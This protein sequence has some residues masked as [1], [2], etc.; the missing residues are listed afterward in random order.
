MLIISL[1]IAIIL[2]CFW[3][4]C[5]SHNSPID[6]NVWSLT[7]RIASIELYYVGR[8]PIFEL[9][10]QQDFPKDC[11]RKNNCIAAV[12]FNIFISFFFQ[13]SCL[14]TYSHKCKQKNH[15]A[16]YTPSIFTLMNY[17]NF[18]QQETSKNLTGDPF[19]NLW[20]PF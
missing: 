16:F 3:T 11:K 20:R 13:A 5:S 2:M 9:Q 19:R 10:R 12:S 8:Y 17:K 4:L 7:V 14:L 15:K 18:S 6:R 1:C